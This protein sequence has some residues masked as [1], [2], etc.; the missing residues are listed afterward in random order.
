MLSVNSNSGQ[1]QT[2]HELLDNL[3]F[4]G[5]SAGAVALQAAVSDTVRTGVARIARV[6]GEAVNLRIGDIKDTITSKKGSYGDPSGTITVG[7]RTTWLADFLSASQKTRV[8]LGEGIRR[9]IGGIVINVR[10]RASGRFGISEMIPR[11]FA[12][13]MIKRNKFVGIFQREGSSRLPI[14][15]LRGPTALGVF[16]NAQGESGG[17]TII[18]DM[19]IEL[20]DVLA[21]NISNQIDR[22]LK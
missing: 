17:Q 2:V 18:D 20:Q 15:R 13:V 6:I 22:F 1:L 12:G 21:K 9:T 16:M 11:G 4:R 7:R 3:Q 8:A 5:R 19:V 14:H 10:K